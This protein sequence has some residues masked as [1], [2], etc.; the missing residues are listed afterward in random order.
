MLKKI[1]NILIT[2]ILLLL[3]A[4]AGALF[5]PK[6]LGYNMF[7][8]VSGSMEPN[9]PVGAI[10]YTKE[11]PFEDI[12]VGDVISFRISEDTMVTHRVIEVDEANQQFTTKGDANEV[13]DG[14]LVAYGNVVGEVALSIPH[15]G[16]FSSLIRTPLGIA[17]ACGVVFLMILLN[18]LPEIFEKEEEK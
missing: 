14:S 3:L 9:I 6:V 17:A 11:V 15:L 2:I 16:T 8:V 5:L 18:F 12:E 13:E 1:C 4:L 7:N 10:V